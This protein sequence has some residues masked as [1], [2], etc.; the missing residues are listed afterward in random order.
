M[1]FDPANDTPDVM[2][3]YSTR[4]ADHP[5]AAPWHFV[6][7][8]SQSDLDPI[9]TAY[10]QAVDKKNN[11]HDPTGPLNHTMRVFLI[12]PSGNVRNIYS[13]ATLDP[14]LVLADVRTLIMES[15]R[16]SAKSATRPSP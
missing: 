4:A 1:S 6:T 15:P 5:D 16:P 11:P 3:A 12:D 2:A 7:A 9:L 13:S 10:G 8:S 14:R